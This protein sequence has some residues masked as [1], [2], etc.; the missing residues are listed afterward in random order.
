MASNAT[1]EGRAN[2]R[3]VES[4]LERGQE[5]VGGSGAQRPGTGGSGTQVPVQQGGTG[6]QQQAPV[7]QGRTGGSGTL[8]P[9]FPEGSTPPQPGGSDT[10]SPRG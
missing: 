8:D 10:Q 7:Q 1:P 6:T 4:I 5:A 2:N 9:Q 3:R